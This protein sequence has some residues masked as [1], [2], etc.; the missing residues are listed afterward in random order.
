MKTLF[1]ALVLFIPASSWCG[2]EGLSEHPNID[3]SG[4][5]D[6]MEIRWIHR[7]RKRTIEAFLDG[8]KHFVGYQAKDSH[9]YG[10]QEKGVQYEIW[11]WLILNPRFLPGD[12]VA[13]YY[14][15]KDGNGWLRVDS[16][17][18][19]SHLKCKTLPND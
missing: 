6:G 14:K 8:Q 5:G 19:F 12:F 2:E 9:D 7:P 3:C 4:F 18:Y 16:W 13:S 10:V 11:G 1:F 17:A 15:D